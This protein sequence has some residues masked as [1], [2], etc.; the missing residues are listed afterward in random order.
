MRLNLLLKDA[1]NN[2]FAVD[3]YYHSYSCKKFAD[4]Y[5]PVEPQHAYSTKRFTL[6]ILINNF[7]TKSV[8]E[9]CTFLLYELISYFTSIFDDE[10]LHIKNY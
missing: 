7:R 2:L 6:D 3:L 8:K 4:L 5:F 10:G 9:K 1:S